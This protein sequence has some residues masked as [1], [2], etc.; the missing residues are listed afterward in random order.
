[1]KQ[2][3]ALGFLILVGLLASGC[4]ASGQNGASEASTSP[5]VQTLESYLTALVDKDEARL[6][7]MVCPDY[8]ADALLEYDS[9]GAVKTSLDGLSCKQTGQDGDSILVTCQGKIRASYSNETQDFDLGKR[10][11]RLKPQGND[12]LVCGYTKQ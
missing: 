4:A 3:L 10:V 7:N 11:Y 12:W 2:L 5:A 9:F 1:M 6:S 8:E